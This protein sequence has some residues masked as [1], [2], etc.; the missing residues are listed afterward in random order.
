MKANSNPAFAMDKFSGDGMKQMEDMMSMGKQSADAWMKFGTIFAKG[1]EEMMKTCMTRAQS[2][3]E[4]NSDVMKSL[5][6]CKTINEFA[7]TQN[8][9]A[10]SS[11]EEAMSASAQMSEMSVKVMMDC[12]EPI[13]KQMS[14]AMKKVAV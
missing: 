1:M 8:R 11:M 4:K 3:G 2:A 6:G 7:E 10:Q 12:M 13:N 14:E 9:I 5:M